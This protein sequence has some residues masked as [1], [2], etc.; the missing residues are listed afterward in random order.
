MTV[1]LTHLHS[2]PFFHLFQMPFKMKRDSSLDTTPNHYSWT[3]LKEIA[4][5][6]TVIWLLL[7]NLVLVNLTQLRVFCR[8]QRQITVKFTYQTQKKNMIT[9]FITQAVN[10]STQVVQNRVDLTH[11]KYLQHQKMKVKKVKTLHLQH[12]CSSWNNSL[13]SS[14]MVLLWM[15]LKF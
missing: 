14:L 9:Q 1:V 15:R 6:L 12:T 8:T 11:S 13:K 5:E 2:L 3:S 7:V 10:L 4:R